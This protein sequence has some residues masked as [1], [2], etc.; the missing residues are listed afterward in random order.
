VPI[1][2]SEPKLPPTRCELA[3]GQAFA[4]R[5]VDQFL[6]PALARI[7]LGN[8]RQRPVEI[9][10]GYV[11]AELGGEGA[12]AAFGM[13]ATVEQ[14][15]LLA[16]FFE[17]FADHNKAARKDLYMVARTSGLFGA[18]LD[19]G[20]EALAVCESIHAG[21]NDFGDLGGKLASVIGRPGLHDHRP[22]LNGARNIKRT[23]NG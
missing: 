2:S 23:A 21:E 22:A 7:R 17:R 14:R 6:P 1:I 8:V 12:N 10:A 15:L 16:R 20:V 3:D 11:M 19:V 5:H 13:D 9:E 18:S 4:F